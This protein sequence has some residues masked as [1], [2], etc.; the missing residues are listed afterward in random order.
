MESRKNDNEIMSDKGKELL[1]VLRR[2]IESGVITMEMLND[3]NFAEDLVNIY[4]ELK[5]KKK[6]GDVIL[7]LQK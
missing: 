6:K 5:S 1:G 2:K 3:E 4:I 7:C